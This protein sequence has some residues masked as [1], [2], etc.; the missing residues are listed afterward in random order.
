MDEEKL[1]AASEAREGEGEWPSK[2]WKIV[3]CWPRVL[4]AVADRGDG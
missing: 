2:L 4:A 1:R 3:P